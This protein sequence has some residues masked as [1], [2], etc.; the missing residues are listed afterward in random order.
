MI[1]SILTQRNHS[2]QYLIINKKN[3]YLTA[4][5]NKDNIMVFQFFR[6]KMEFVLD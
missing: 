2:K 3:N 4:P 1:S 6:K 5:Q